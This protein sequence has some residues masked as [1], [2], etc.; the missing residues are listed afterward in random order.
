M[1]SDS[2][3]SCNSQVGQSGR[4]AF[5]PIDRVRFRRVSRS[6][7]SILLSWSLVC[8]YLFRSELVFQV[9]V[10]RVAVF[11]VAVFQVADGRQRLV[12]HVPSAQ[13]RSV[14][15]AGLSALRR[16]DLTENPAD[17]NGPLHSQV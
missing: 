9:T 1:R 13:F 11:R 16:Q 6:E 5:A 8:P 12:R 3:S 15:L 10:F 7:W 17:F 14:K 2:V 4:R